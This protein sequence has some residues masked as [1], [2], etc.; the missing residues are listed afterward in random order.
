MAYA[1]FGWPD[2]VHPLTQ[3]AFQLSLS[4][5]SGTSGVEVCGGTHDRFQ[6]PFT[7]F[8]R[9]GRVGLLVSVRMLP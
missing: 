1:Q 3:R 8:H 6:H 2:A 4:F 9:R 7:P 5:S